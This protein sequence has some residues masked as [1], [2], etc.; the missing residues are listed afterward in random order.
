MARVGGCIMVHPRREPFG[1]Q[2]ASFA[3]GKMP[4]GTDS[5]VFLS[6]LPATRRDR[7]VAWAV[8]GVSAL[9]FACAVPFAGMPL[10]PVPAFVASY[11]SA[12]AVN[13]LIT[14]ILLL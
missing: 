6:T 13:D 11:Q 14:A 4:R 1:T 2:G 12:L 8:V 9:L 5:N 7:Q 10:A 3:R